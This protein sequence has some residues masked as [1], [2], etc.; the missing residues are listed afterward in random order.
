MSASVKAEQLHEICVL[1]RKH[2]GFAL[3]GSKRLS[4]RPDPIYEC[5][6]VLGGGGRPV[7]KHVN[8][9]LTLYWYPLPVFMQIMVLLPYGN[10]FLCS[11][12]V[13][14]ILEGKAHAYVFASP[15]CKKW[16]TAAPEAIVHAM[17]GKLTDIHGN[18]LQYHKTVRYQNLAGVLATKHAKDHDMYKSLIPDHVK[19]ALPPA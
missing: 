7:C 12:Q 14:L 15:G 5:V 13:M 9:I 6:C 10:Q 2:T 16:D 3:G 8:P 11:F 4:G 18:R 19:A 1:P 17:G